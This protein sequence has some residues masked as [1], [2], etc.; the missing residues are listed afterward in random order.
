[1]VFDP[2]LPEDRRSLYSAAV[3]G[4]ESKTMVVYDEPF[5]RADGLSGQSAGAGSPCE[6][7]ID[8]SPADARYGVLA[9]FAFSHVARRL[10]VM[11]ED[12]RRQAILGTLAERFGRRTGS[13]A[14]FVTTAWWD[15]PWS[16]GCSM[17]HFPCGVLTRYGHLLR[18]PF[19]RVHFAGTETSTRSHGAVDG[20]VRSGERAADEILEAQAT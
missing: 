4:V 12:E 16:R 3:A 17:A 9:C 10:D 18:Q 2:A 15:E 7:T 13:P 1:M 8:A 14:D 6:V 11:K 19:G 20:A 5:W